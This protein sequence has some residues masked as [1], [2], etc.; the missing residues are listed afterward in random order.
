MH[1]I[2]LQN[3]ADFFWCLFKNQILAEHFSSGYILSCRP[4]S[5]HIIDRHL[6]FPGRIIS[7]AFAGCTPFRYSIETLSRP[8]LRIKI[9]PP[10]QENNPSKPRKQENKKGYAGRLAKAFNYRKMGGPQKPCAST[11]SAQVVRQRLFEGGDFQADFRG[12]PWQ[13]F[14]PEPAVL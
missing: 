11:S 5:F 13:G 12:W 2:V 8:S 7:L 6:L 9:R 1:H 14:F 3:S 4:R 10:R